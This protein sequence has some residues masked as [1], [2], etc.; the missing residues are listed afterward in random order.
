MFIKMAY[1][2]ELFNLIAEMSNWAVL[3]IDIGDLNCSY[4]LKKRK[5]DD[6]TEILLK[7]PKESQIYTVFEHCFYLN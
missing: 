1:Q 3:S 2:C 7:P 4:G 6:P 5:L